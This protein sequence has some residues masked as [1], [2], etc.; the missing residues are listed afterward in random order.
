MRNVG[1]YDT[2]KNSISV[3]RKCSSLFYIGT[4]N[5]N[6]MHAQLQMNYNN[7]LA[8]LYSLHVTDNPACLCSHSVEDTAHFF[9]DYSFY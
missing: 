2:F 1:S 8:H 6:V 9:L 4:R 5:F 7:V 3:V